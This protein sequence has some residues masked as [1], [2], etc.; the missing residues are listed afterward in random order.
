MT[1]RWRVASA[2][3]NYQ[4]SVLTGDYL[5]SNRLMDGGIGLLLSTDEVPGM[6]TTTALVG[7]AYEA[8]LGRKVRYNHL[9]AGFQ[10]GIVHRA[11]LQ[12]NYTY[13]DQFDGVGFG[14]PTAEVYSGTNLIV[15]DFNLGLLWY[16]TQK[17]RGNPELNPFAGVSVQHINRPDI[18]FLGDGSEPLN[19]RYTFQLGTKYRTRTPIDLNASVIFALQNNSNQL[20]ANFF[21]RYVF[22]N[23][24]ITFGEH[25]ASIMLGMV[26]RSGDALVGYAGFELR[27]TFSFGVA[28]DIYVPQNTFAQ[29]AFGGLHANV[30]YLFGR[31]KYSDPALPFPYF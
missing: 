8:P 14:R 28:F 17:I 4:T 12:G 3:E 13:E 5:L 19:M 20:T 10:G 23:E 31:K 29:N 22:Y 26:Y 27:E 9:R 7:F 21:A 30:A 11:L 16:R 1:H 2:T 18:S 25:K 15:P 24:G 6:R